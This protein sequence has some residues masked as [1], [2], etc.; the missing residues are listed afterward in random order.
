MAPSSEAVRPYS[1][2]DGGTKAVSNGAKLGGCTAVHP[3]SCITW[4]QKGFK[5]T[6][7]RNR[8]S[9]LAKI[10]F[11]TL[12]FRNPRVPNTRLAEISEPWRSEH[13]GRLDLRNPRVPNFL[14]GV[15]RGTPIES[16]FNQE[17][18]GISQTSHFPIARARHQ[19]DGL[20]FNPSHWL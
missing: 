7:K 16:K 11:R 15:P 10:G 4:R 17:P 9:W 20:I 19:E 1:L 18:G 14:A 5:K 6:T 8:I 12:K 13:P 2:R 3:P